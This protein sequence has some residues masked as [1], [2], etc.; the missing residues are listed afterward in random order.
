MLPRPSLGRCIA[1]S[2]SLI[3]CVSAGSQDSW[4]TSNLQDLACS[5]AYQPHG[6]ARVRGGPLSRLTSL[7][8]TCIGM[9]IISQ[10]QLL[11]FCQRQLKAAHSSIARHTAALPQHQYS[12]S[13]THTHRGCAIPRP[14][15]SH[16]RLQS[17]AVNT[18]QRRTKE[19]GQSSSE[20]ETANAVAFLQGV[21]V[22]CS[23]LSDGGTASAQWLQVA[24]IL[25]G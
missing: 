5:T 3:A 2:H 4:L 12:T 13:C 15:C 16:I 11:D 1:A 17:S 6:A 10:R 21:L 7:R 14:L 24:G 22:D 8:S 25:S 18:T 9:Q 19:P 20:R 23:L